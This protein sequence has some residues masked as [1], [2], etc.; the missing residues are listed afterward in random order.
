MVEIKKNMKTRILADGTELSI[1]V[2]NFPGLDKASPSVYIQSGIHGSEVQGYLVALQLIEYFTKHPPKGDITIVPIANPYGLNCK[3]GE[4]TFGRFDPVTGDNWNRNYMDLSIV[5]DNFFEEYKDYSFGKLVPLFKARLQKNIEER[6]SIETSY[7][8]KLAL[9][10]QS[11]STRADIVLDLHCDTISVPHIYCPSYAMN[12]AMHLGIEFII[13]IPHKFGGALDEASFCPWVLLAEKYSA[14]HKIKVTP[15]IEA[16]TVELGNQE[17]IEPEN[18]TK[19]LKGIL[20]YLAVK[21]AIDL[22]KSTSIEMQSIYSCKLDKFMTIYTPCGGLI[23][24]HANLGKIVEAKN[25]LVS[26]NSPALWK[27][28]K[29]LNNFI[30]GTSISIH[31]DHDSIPIT[32]CPSSIAHEGIALMKIMTDYK[33]MN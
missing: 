26:I 17:T 32:R 1:P 23:L 19:Q 25:P 8:K 7:H 12:S 29:S 27:N 24:Q 13:E 6:L 5:L 20:N 9:Q 16:F 11:L 14:Y 2:F 15:P 4:Y 22:K 18:S 28:I 21:G 10:I 3:M 33:K 30:D 31:K